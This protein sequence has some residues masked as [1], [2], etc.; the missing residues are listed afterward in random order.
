MHGTIMIFFA[1][2]PLLIGALGT[3]VVP[4]AIGA[5][6]MA[7]PSLSPLSFWTNV[8]AGIVLVVSF[9]VPSGR[10]PAAGPPTRR[11]R[12]PSASRG[13]AKQCGSSRSS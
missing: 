13:R 1:V 7:F 9:F 12:R 11:S 4:L 2:S 8:A 3:Y 5:R 10:P 6:N